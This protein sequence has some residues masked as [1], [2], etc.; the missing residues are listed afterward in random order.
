MHLIVIIPIREAHIGNSIQLTAI[1]PFSS[2]PSKTVSRTEREGKIHN[3]KDD[4][5]I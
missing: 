4:R 3:L 2:K 5:L 1:H